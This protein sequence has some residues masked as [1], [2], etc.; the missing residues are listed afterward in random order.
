MA[1]SSRGPFSPQRHPHHGALDAQVLDAEQDASSG[2]DEREDVGA[3]EQTDVLL[4]L[5]A[6][7]SDRGLSEAGEHAGE[8]AVGEL[9]AA[10][11]MPSTLARG[12]A[13]SARGA[14]RAEGNCGTAALVG[15]ACGPPLPLGRLDAASGACRGDGFF[16]RLLLDPE[17]GL[18][19]SAP[20]ERERADGEL[21]RPLP[22]PPLLPWPMAAVAPWREAPRAAPLA[23]DPPRVVTSCSCFRAGGK[24][25]SQ[26][27]RAPRWELGSDG[28][29]SGGSLDRGAWRGASWGSLEARRKGGAPGTLRPEP[30]PRA[31]MRWPPSFRERRNAPRWLLLRRN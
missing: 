26:E 12:A 20:P 22:P 8:D 24:P 19:A 23:L 31:S 6:C 13:R 7:T 21:F 9:S 27:L 4:A 18:G 2:L 1:G 29:V 5:L 16:R 15:S 14:P 28:T 25:A 30:T 11:P 17:L 10:E 3:E